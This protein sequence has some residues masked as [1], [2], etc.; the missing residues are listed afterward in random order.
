MAELWDFA[1][2]SDEKIKIIP[3]DYDNDPFILRMRELLD[4][5]KDDMD[6]CV[7]VSSRTY[8]VLLSRYEHILESMGNYITL[9]FPPKVIVESRKE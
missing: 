2:A 3:P 9:F 4:Y 6:K 7:D 5:T 1:R 8:R